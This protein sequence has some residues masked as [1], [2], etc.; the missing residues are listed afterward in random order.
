[1]TYLHVTW[2]RGKVVFFA[3]VCWLTVHGAVFAQPAQ[4]KQ[5]PGGG[6]YVVSYAIVI[7]TIAMGMMAVCRP[8]RRRDR[9]KPEIYDEIKIS[10]ND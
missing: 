1:M 6:H 8:S 2:Q 3:M 9:A 4:Q 5:E 7:L 10:A